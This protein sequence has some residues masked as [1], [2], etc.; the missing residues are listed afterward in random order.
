MI[1]KINDVSIRETVFE[2]TTEAKE[3]QAQDNISSEVEPL[4]QATPEYKSGLIAE[5]RMG[6]QAQEMLLRNQL[7]QSEQA[8]AQTNDVREPKTFTSGSEPVIDLDKTPLDL[9]TDTLKQ[10]PEQVPAQLKSTAGAVA[11]AWSHPGDA[12]RQAEEDAEQLWSNIKA[13]K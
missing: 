11:D 1:D 10:L 2:E 4:I 5:R 8:A 9:V 7:S 12:L 13:G 6:G 3:P